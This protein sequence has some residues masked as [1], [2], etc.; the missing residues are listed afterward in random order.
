MGSRHLEGPQ[1]C[2][3]I[4]WTRPVSDPV[5]EPRRGSGRLPVG[6]STRVSYLVGLSAWR[7]TCWK[8]PS[9][10]VRSCFHV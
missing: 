2:K 5:R 1:L 7:S 6:L 9:E 8:D 10:I 4:G 3:L